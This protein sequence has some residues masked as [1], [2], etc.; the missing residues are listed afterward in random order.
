MQDAD[1]FAWSGRPIRNKRKL[2]FRNNFYCTDFLGVGNER[3]V[4]S[5]DSRGR[6][7]TCL[8]SNS[9]VTFLTHLYLNHYFISRQQLDLSNGNFKVSWKYDPDTKE[10]IFKI[11]AKGTGWLGLGISKL[12]KGMKEMD[13]AVLSVKNGGAHIEVSW[14]HARHVTWGVA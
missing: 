14:R 5:P 11:I 3:K 6:S 9:L 1:W 8:E 12:N 10:I 2:N 7:T 4:M 13:I